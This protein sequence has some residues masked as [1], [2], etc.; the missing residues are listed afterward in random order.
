MLA[1]TVKF[2]IHVLKLKSTILASNTIEAYV[3]AD[4]GRALTN[5]GRPCGP[6][7]LLISSC[8]KICLYWLTQILEALSLL[9]LLGFKKVYSRCDSN[10]SACCFYNA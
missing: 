3:L 6:T 4:L 7:P 2:H 9:I 8:N 10:A 1:K 5:L